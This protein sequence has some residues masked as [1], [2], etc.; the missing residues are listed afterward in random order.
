MLLG[1][2]CRLKWKRAKQSISY[3]WTSGFC[4]PESPMSR[5][6]VHFRVCL[7]EILLSHL[8]P[9]WRQQGKGW[10]CVVVGTSPNLSSSSHLSTGDTF[11]CSFRLLHRLFFPQSVKCFCVMPRIHLQSCIFK[12]FERIC[13]LMCSA[14]GNAS[15]YAQS[16]QLRRRDEKHRFSAWL[17]QT[18][19]FW[20]CKGHVRLHWHFSWS[21]VA[22]QLCPLRRRASDI[23]LPLTIWWGATSFLNQ[24]WSPWLSLTDP[25]TFIRPGPAQPW[26]QTYSWLDPEGQ[27]KHPAVAMV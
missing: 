7:L 4:F 13:A 26:A 22:F 24:T 14:I 23:P 19:S 9:F 6:P 25:K 16:Q 2:E 18:Q 15:T 3:G 11:L 8:V 10:E 1:H 12:C 20:P 27:S 17:Q 5:N 21:P